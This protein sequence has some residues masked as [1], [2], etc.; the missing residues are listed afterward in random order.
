MP[1]SRSDFLGLLPMKV[2]VIRDPKESL[3]KC[4]LTPLQSRPDIEFIRFQP[5]HRFLAEGMIFL[6]PGGEPLKP[7]DRGRTV[8]LLD[9]SWK[10][11][12]KL[13]A[14]L[15]GSFLPRSLPG[16]FVSA[17][18]RKSKVF[19]DPLEGLAS[20]EALFITSFILGCPDESLLAGYY[21]KERF[22]SVNQKQFQQFGESP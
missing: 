19:Q 5:Q 17:Y 21:W 22:L 4:S 12:R 11:V 8:L 15:T 1:G 20:V 13:Q 6:T 9:S 14:S 10:S 16:G 2:V 18:P 3:K 7:E